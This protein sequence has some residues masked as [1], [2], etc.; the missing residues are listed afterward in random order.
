M[1]NDAMG[2]HPGAP[3]KEAT[4]GVKHRHPGVKGRSIGELTTTWETGKIRKLDL[5]G[6]FSLSV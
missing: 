5:I 3:T 6:T 2:H 1:A 4:A